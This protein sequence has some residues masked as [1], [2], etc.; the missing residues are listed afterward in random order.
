M[1]KKTAT[2]TTKTMEHM[3]CHFLPLKTHHTHGEV[4]IYN[5]PQKIF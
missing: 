5:S 1:F 2:A 3:T 4:Y